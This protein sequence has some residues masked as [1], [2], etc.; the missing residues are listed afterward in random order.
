[1]TPVT[2]VVAGKWNEF[3]DWQDRQPAEVR[4]SYRYVLNRTDL[5]AHPDGTHVRFVGT[6]YRRGDLGVLND[7]ISDRNFTVTYEG[8][9]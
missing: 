6:Y 3:R 5:L 8:S 9:L 7:V 4:K 1:M 2:L